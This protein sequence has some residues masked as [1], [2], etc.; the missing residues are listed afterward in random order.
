MKPELSIIVP[1][2][3]VKCYLDKC[4]ESIL[5]QTFKNFELIL[6]NDGS[7]DTSLEICRKYE[8]LDKRIIVIN[9]SNGGV[10]RARNAGLEIARGKW[11]GFVDA[12]DYIDKDFYEILVK[13]S[14]KY[15]NVD[16]ACCG[17]KVIDVNSTKIKHLQYAHIPQQETLLSK[18]DAYLHFFHPSKRYLYWSPWDKIIRADIAKKFRF[19]PGRKYAEDFFYCFQC[20]TESNAILYIPEKKYNYLI[21]PGSAIQSARFTKS[22]FDSSYF[23]QKAYD[24]IEKTNPKSKLYAEMNLLIVSAR[25]IR[26]FYKIGND[27]KSLSIQ[28]KKLEQIIRNGSKKA[29][30]ALKLS[31]KILLFEA[32]YMPFLFKIR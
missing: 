3:N 28:V 29:K 21:R 32:V 9:Q 5:K 13:K 26:S 7:E 19:E 4:I 31:H 24:S 22:S 15:K 12:D 1:I 18:E 20:I 17:V 2:Y 25:T 27:D 6:I 10:S 8:K 23:A 16:I 30:K 11:I 14:L